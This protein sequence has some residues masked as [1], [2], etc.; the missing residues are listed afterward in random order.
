MK[1][2]DFGQVFTPYRLVVDILDAAGYRGEGI[3]GRHI[4]DNSCGDGAFLTEIVDRY[5][6]EYYKKYQ[7]YQGIAKDL[8]QYIHGIEYDAEVW[9]QCLINLSV[10][11]AEYNIE[12]IDFDILNADALKTEKYN[13]RMDFVVGNPPY[14]RIHNLDSQYETVRNFAFCAS[15]MTDLYIVFYEIGIKMLNDTGVLCYITPNSFYNSIAGKKLR[16]YLNDNRN[17]SMLMDLGH[18]QPFGF[19]SYTTICRICMKNDSDLCQYY[20]YDAE[21]ERPVFVANIKY[22]DLFVGGNIVLSVDNRKYL[23][24]LNYDLQSRPQKVIVKN[25]FATLNDKIFIRDDFDFSENVI[26]VLKASTGQWK[27]CLYP[28]DL[29]GKL[30]PFDKLNIK[31]RQYLQ[32][33]YP[34][35]IDHK[36]KK[37]TD[38]YGFGRSQALN[39]VKYQKIAINNCVKDIESIKLNPVDANQGVYSGFYLLTDHSYEAIKQ[40]ICSAEFIGYIQTLNKCK[41]GGYYTFSSKDLAKYINCCMEDSANEQ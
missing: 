19:A 30:L 41:S 21:T 4:I 35:L 8:R 5:I 24:Y 10:K 11:C 3:L 33:N 14:V 17:I 28:Y 37:D 16:E 39:D 2:K 7:S 31:A 26:D 13:G 20:K 34:Y 18:Y 40:K 25:G 38:W 29:N 12:D 23:K 36:K 22:E 6:N 9:R 15:G 27:K 1:V 32:K